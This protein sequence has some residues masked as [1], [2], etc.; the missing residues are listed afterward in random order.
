MSERFAYVRVSSRTQNEARQVNAIKERYDIDDEHIIIEKASGKNFVGREKYQDLRKKLQKGDLLI[1]ASLDRLGRNMVE[2]A[3]E[4]QHLTKAGIDIDVLDMPLLCTRRNDSDLTKQ[5][6]NDIIVKIL[7]YV[8]EKERK[9]ILERQR[10]GIDNALKNGTKEG[11]KA[12]GRPKM[13]QLPKDFIKYY[14]AGTYKAGEVQKL[15]GLTKTTYYR[16]AKLFDEQRK[17]V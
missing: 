11:K 13:Q 2:T 16:Y 14:S 9:N 1:I 5:L 10:Q 6:I 7:C 8:G 4:W 17:A 12:F 3:E 15:C